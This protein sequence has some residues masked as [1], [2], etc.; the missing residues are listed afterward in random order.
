MQGTNDEYKDELKLENF[1]TACEKAGIEVSVN[2]EEG[3]D[4]GFYFIS[5]FI[6]QHFHHHS[7]F[8]CDSW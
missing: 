3:Y 1:L 8:L 7:K 4:H 5:S 6:E 2:Y